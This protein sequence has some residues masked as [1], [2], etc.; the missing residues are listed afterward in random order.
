[1]TRR[2]DFSEGRTLCAR[3]DRPDVCRGMW[4]PEMGIWVAFRLAGM[5]LGEAQEFPAGVQ[6]PPLRRAVRGKVA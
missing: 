1:M 3:K 6:S 2:P 5:C 4:L